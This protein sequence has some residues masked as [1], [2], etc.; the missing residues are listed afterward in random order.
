MTSEMGVAITSCN[1]VKGG[2]AEVKGLEGIV[3]ICRF[4][5]EKGQCLDG[6]KQSM[7]NLLK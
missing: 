7:S 2:S 4:C 6:Q 5:K 3:E 1:L